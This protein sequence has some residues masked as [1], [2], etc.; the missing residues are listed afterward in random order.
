MSD[1]FIPTGVAT[2]VSGSIMHT[3]VTT[4]IPSVGPTGFFIP[5]AGIYYAYG[6]G[7]DVN[8]QIQDSAGVWQDVWAA[9]VGGIFTSDAVNVRFVNLGGYAEDVT[10]IKVG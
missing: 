6:V 5:D 1:D 8:L 3:E 7:A 10:L 4:S 2:G 9:A